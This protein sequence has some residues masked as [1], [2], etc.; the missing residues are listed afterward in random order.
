MTTEV[1][2]N[3]L[4][5]GRVSQKKRPSWS[6]T[7][8]TTWATRSAARPGKSRS[9]WPAVDPLVCLS[10]TVPNLGRDSRLDPGGPWRP[11]RRSCTSSAPFRS[12][13]ATSVDGKEHVV[14][15]GEGRR[16]G[17]FK[18]IGGELARRITRRVSGEPD[19]RP[20]ALGRASTSRGSTRRPGGCLVA[21]VQQRHQPAPW[22]VMRAPG[23]RGA[24]PGHLLSVQSPG[25]RGS[26]R[27]LHRP[28]HRPARG[29]SRARSQAA[30]GRPIAA[31]TVICAR[32][33]S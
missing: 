27:V 5:Q 9:C 10:A 20:G 33:G 19:R 2:R 8:S 25:L 14:I 4:V 31:P 15:D 18:G 13:I 12:S 26:R 22:E 1:L 11:D 24:D 16:R 21:R 7:R 28:A 3:M 23:A 29:R 30:P 17:S 6:S 32:S